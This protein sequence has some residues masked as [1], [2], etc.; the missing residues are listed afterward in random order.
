M[1]GVK[2]YQRQRMLMAASI[3]CQAQL[4]KAVTGTILCLP[5]MATAPQPLANPG[6]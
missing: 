4:L 5:T 2:A 1:Q 3:K 6:S